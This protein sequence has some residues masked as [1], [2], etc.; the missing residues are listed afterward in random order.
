LTKPEVQIN[1][2]WCKSCEICVK[3][4]PRKVL[5]MGRFTAQVVH[6]ENCNGCKICE[7]LCPDFAIIVT[8]PEKEKEE[9]K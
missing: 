1:P 9:A 7:S 2:D 6:P 3:F 5:E 8:V 4:C